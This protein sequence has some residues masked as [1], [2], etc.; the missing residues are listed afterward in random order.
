[1]NQKNLQF[2]KSLSLKS[3]QAK[4][5]KAAAAAAENA[6]KP[7]PKKPKK[8]L[9]QIELEIR[10]I[11]NSVNSKVSENETVVI[12]QG[13]K[14]VARKAAI[15]IYR[16]EDLL[17]QKEEESAKRKGLIEKSFK[18]VPRVMYAFYPSVADQ[19]KLGSI[20]IYGENPSGTCS[21]IQKLGSLFG[22]KVL[23]ASLEM[24]RRMFVDVTLA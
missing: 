14:N 18:A 17:R 2:N 8:T 6:R 24:G 5:K 9:P 12:S 10:S 3:L 11:L 13:D 4:A 16:R 22:H 21:I 20:A 1:M 19:N 7:A 23:R 15:S